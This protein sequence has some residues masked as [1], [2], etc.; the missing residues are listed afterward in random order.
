MNTKHTETPKLNMTFKARGLNV[1]DEEGTFKI[2]TNSETLAK[3]VAHRLNNHER[4]LEACKDVLS[5]L[6]SGLEPDTYRGYLI[7]QLN[8][9]INAVESEN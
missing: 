9:A 1:S 7:D 5:H 2:A 4:L 8:N 6:G 3:L